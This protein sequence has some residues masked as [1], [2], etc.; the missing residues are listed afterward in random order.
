MNPGKIKSGLTVASAKS[1]LR[2][3]Y[4][5]TSKPK[6]TLVDNAKDRW[7]LALS[8]VE[9]QGRLDYFS[10]RKHWSCA[11]IAWITVLVVFNIAL[12]VA[13]GIGCLVFEQE[14]FVT[15]VTIETFL[16]IVAMGVVAVNYLFSD[17]SPPNS[18]S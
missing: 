16:Q 15:A 5:Q 4:Q 6:D 10:L 9:A 12:T 13:V 14:W 17:N 8:D 1:R 3:A 7:V 11:M 18:S 2:G